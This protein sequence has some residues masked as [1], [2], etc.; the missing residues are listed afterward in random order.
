[1]L[2]FDTFVDTK[3]YICR[4]TSIQRIFNNKKILP[5]YYFIDRTNA[6]YF[7]KLDNKASWWLFSPSSMTK[8]AIVNNK[9]GNKHANDT[10]LGNG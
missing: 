7:M 9:N 3:F 2:S 4:E 8:N 6:L 10:I 5:I 1:M